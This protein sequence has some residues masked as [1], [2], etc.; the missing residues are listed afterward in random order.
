MVIY[1]DK[2]GVAN[3]IVP[4]RVSIVG[5]ILSLWSDGVPVVTVGKT[6]EQIREMKRFGYQQLQIGKT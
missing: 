3:F 6:I 5:P 2:G 1:V 4:L